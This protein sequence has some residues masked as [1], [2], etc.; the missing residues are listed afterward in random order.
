MSA[1]IQFGSTPEGFIPRQLADIQKAINEDL[2]I[3]ENPKTGE[4]PFQ[5]AT[6][7]TILQQVVAKFAEQTGRVENA[8]H[9][10]FQQR[11]PL[12]ATGA[13]LSQVVQINGI[14]RQPGSPT[15]VPELLT[16]TPGTLIPVGSLI[17]HE[18]SDVIYRINENV[19]LPLEGQVTVSAYS[20][21]EGPYD[22]AVG[23]VV[24]ILTPVAGWESA[25]NRRVLNE[26]TPDEIVIGV[27]SIGTA[28]ETDEQLRRR[29]QVSTNATSYRQ[30]EAIRAA[31]ANIAG[32]TFI[33]GYQNRMLETDD[34][35]IPGKTV[36]CVVV[37]GDSRLIAEAILMRS[38]LGVGFWGNVSETFYDS[39]NIATAVQFSRPIER[40]VYV[41]INMEIVIDEGIQIFP[42]NGISLIK[43]AII[44]FAQFGHSPCEPIGNPGFPPG[45]DIIASWLSTPINSVGGAKINSI[46]LSFDGT[47]WTTDELDITWDEHGVF[48]EARIEIDLP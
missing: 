44:D 46:E 16:G 28:E 22:P 1:D 38:P 17:G 5:N 14:V 2:S 23:T 10:A 29:Q 30:I 12:T 43:Q 26:G 15:I 34:R 3:I 47:A 18:G 13:G 45:Q 42:S 33:R 8:A 40:D 6:D 27:S 35:G 39:Q 20:T 7:D 19:V 48:D 32:V 41:R 37:G 36:A 21:T 9:E 25:T 11:D 4:R 24:N 31:V